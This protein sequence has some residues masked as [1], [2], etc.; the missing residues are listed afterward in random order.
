SDIPENLPSSS[1]SIEIEN[2]KLDLSLQV[3][4]A[5]MELTPKYRI[6][7][8]LKHLQNCHYSDIAN[9]LGLPENKVKS[10]LYSGRQL[11]RKILLRKRILL[12]D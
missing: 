6:V 10:R 3:Q 5:I 8:I 4:N 7:I 9:I 12:N 2:E 11:L 1:Q